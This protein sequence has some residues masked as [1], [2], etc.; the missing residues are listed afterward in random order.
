MNKVMKKILLGF[1]LS[2]APVYSSVNFTGPLGSPAENG[3]TNKPVR[4]TQLSLLQSGLAAQQDVA[5]RQKNKDIIAW[6]N[7]KQVLDVVPEP[8]I[9]NNNHDALPSWPD[10]VNVTPRRMQFGHD[11]HNVRSSSQCDAIPVRRHNY[12]VQQPQAKRRLLE[13]RV[14]EKDDQSILEFFDPN[15]IPVYKP[16]IDG[17]YDVEDIDY[18]TGKIRRKHDTSQ[19]AAASVQNEPAVGFLCDSDDSGSYRQTPE[20]GNYLA[21]P[22]KKKHKK[23]IHFTNNSN[24]DVR[25]VS[26][27]QRSEQIDK[28]KVL[29]TPSRGAKIDAYLSKHSAADTDDE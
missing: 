29:D 17:F 26:H 11:M 5:A 1:L 8:V 15:Q 23:I 10:S 28:L 13:P 7:S 27:V 20:D 12:S 6:N 21:T 25:H 3:L 24:N 14:I 16:R 4:L 2:V 9:D 19:Q 22:R 18:S